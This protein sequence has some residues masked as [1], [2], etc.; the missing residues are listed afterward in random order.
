MPHSI[1]HGK[2][3]GKG[4]VATTFGFQKTDVDVI[5]LF[6]KWLPIFLKISP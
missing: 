6:G 1:H 2:A 3:S 4:L 5:G